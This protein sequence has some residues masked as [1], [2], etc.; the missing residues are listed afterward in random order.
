MLE[1]RIF[2]THRERGQRSPLSPPNISFS[3][4]LSINSFLFTNSVETSRKT[5][6][7]TWD[8]SWNHYHFFWWN[9]DWGRTATTMFSRYLSRTVVNTTS[10]SRFLSS[11]ASEGAAAVATEANVV[12]PVS[13]LDS[14][15]RAYATGRRKTSVARV[16][17]KE[18]SGQF[19]V[20]NKSFVEYFQPIQRQHCTEPFSVSN[21]S[22]MYDVFC[23]VKGGGISGKN[24]KICWVC[25]PLLTLFSLVLWIGQAGAVRLG[26]SRAL[27]K[28][29]SDFKSPLRKAGL[30]TRDSRMVE[31]KKPGQKKARKQYQ[32]V[33]R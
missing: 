5:F 8:Y 32:W 23:T 20:N 17:I 14:F 16:W 30:L 28:F 11:V 27:E 19:V 6:K 12:A 15:G 33:K 26:I 3:A 22:C 13:Q 2:F 25:C 24:S 7:S 10:R 4:L 21:T 18:G 31:R 9:S 1:G 29:D